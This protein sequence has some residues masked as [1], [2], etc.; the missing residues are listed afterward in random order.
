VSI[1][2]TARVAKIQA[3]V[4]S[5]PDSKLITLR[6]RRLGHTPHDYAYKQDKHAIDVR[7]LDHV[8]AID[9]VAR[10]AIVE[11]EVD[12]G[13]LCAATLPHGLV[14]AV[15]PE[16]ETFTVAGL[17]NGLGIETS[18]H[19][20]GIFPMNVPWFD[21]VLGD[22]ELVRADVDQ[23][24]ELY[25]TV[26]GCYGTLGVVTRAA[27]YL[28]P[29]KAFV[30]S[31]YRH[32]TR[33]A[34]YVRAFADALDAEPFVEGFVLGPDSHVLVTGHFS[35]AAPELGVYHAMKLGNLWYYEHAAKQA[36]R[37]VEDLVP[38]YQ[39][40]FRHMRSLL[41]VS[42]FA[43]FLHLPM[44]RLGRYLIDKRVMSDLASFGLS[45][46]IAHE[47]RERSVVM[48]DVAVSLGRLEAGIA[49]AKQHF[50][51]YP[52]WN[53]AASHAQRGPY[54]KGQPHELLFVADHRRTRQERQ[55]LDERERY[56]VDIGLYGEPTAPGFRHRSAIRALQQFVDMPAAWGVCYLDRDEFERVWDIATYDRVRDAYRATAAFPHIRDKILDRGT[57]LE[58]ESPD[59]GWRF[60]AFCE[61]V[62]HPGRG[63]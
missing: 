61:R 35:D 1:E 57:E 28:V 29:A 21:I 56:M 37:A 33:A 19:R 10:I 16:L 38:T 13:A 53:C 60:K 9:L 48:Q 3:A 63:I 24:R 58:D 59:P 4:R 5:R 11:G 32:F 52:F 12:M 46:G 30:R 31:R 14:P 8:L 20:H 55:A 15:V 26:P 42:R 41:W 47:A 18:S 36:Q 45:S 40:L 51:V 49:Y 7:P 44:T 17:I 50:G 39:Y 43:N 6:K 2:H 54:A 62:L 27:V 34:D 25:T 23:H 22:G